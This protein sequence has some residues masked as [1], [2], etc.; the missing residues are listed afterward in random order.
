M[1]HTYIT[2]RAPV[3][4]MYVQSVHMFVTVL[5]DVEDAEPEL[6]GDCAIALRD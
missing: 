5:V 2:H 4:T 6:E 1:A 3:D